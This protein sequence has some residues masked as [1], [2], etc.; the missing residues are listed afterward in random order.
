MG[1]QIYMNLQDLTGRESGAVLFGNDDILICNWS[2]ISG[3]PRVFATGIIGLGETISAVRC[4]V[5]ET[6][7]S[8]INDYEEEN[9]SSPSKEGFTAWRVNEDCIV[10]T[11]ENWN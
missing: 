5:P 7:I 1:K 6:V 9:G 3:V 8:A 2:Q 10:V 11:Q 4:D